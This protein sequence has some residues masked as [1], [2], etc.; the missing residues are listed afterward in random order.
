VSKIQSDNERRPFYGTDP[1]FDDGP[2]CF[3]VAGL[4]QIEA[5]VEVE[6]AEAGLGRLDRRDLKKKSGFHFVN[7]FF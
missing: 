5:L 4:R 6:A 3:P 2:T 1:C 7:I